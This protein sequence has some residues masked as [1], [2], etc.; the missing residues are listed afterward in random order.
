MYFIMDNR[1]KVGDI[2]C[3]LDEK[4]GGKVVKVSHNDAVILT[5][6]GFEEKHP[7]NSIIKI[8]TQNN[9]RLIN[10]FIPK[11]PEKKSKKNNEQSIFKKKNQLLWEIDVHIENLVEDFYHLSNYEIISL[12]LD[13]CEEIIMKAQKMKVRKLVIIHGKGQGVLRNEIHQMLYSFNLDFKDSDYLKYSGG[14]TDIFF[15]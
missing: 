2:I 14:A 10:A 11:N 13:I 4:G 3:F 15:R 7:L 9:G 1:I 6:E 8:N 5:D 12:Q